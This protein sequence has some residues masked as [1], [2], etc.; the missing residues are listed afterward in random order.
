MR[1]DRPFIQLP[2]RIDPAQL[3]V[4]VAALPASAWRPHPEGAP[5]NSAVPLV[6]HRGD[7][8]DERALPPM[9]A[10]PRLA[11]LP[12]VRA[13]MAALRAP[14]GRSRL[15]RVDSR[16]RLGTHVDT[17]R[18]WQEHLRVHI[19]VVTDP[20]VRFTCDGE[21]VHMAAGEVWVFDTWRE[22][23]V[24]NPAGHD[25]IHLV[26]DTVGSAELWRAIAVGSE[27]VEAADMSSR[28]SRSSADQLR[29]EVNSGSPLA[30]PW[31]QEVLGVRLL[32]DVLES[33]A[34]DADRQRTAVAIRGFLA[35]WRAEWFASD[36]SD[37]VS[38]R[39]LEIGQQL[40]ERLADANVV[41]A[42]GVTIGRAAEQLLL[43][44]TVDP[45][46]PAVDVT[47][48]ASPG[49][50]IERPIFIVSPPRSGSALL[51][52]ALSRASGLYT[53]G[54]ESHLVIESI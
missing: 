33:A 6:C 52:E 49:R 54:G 29:F 42:N 12:G 30:T 14:I 10:S 44:A 27:K 25:R 39:F 24:D 9:A 51:F 36:R 45:Q 1:L 46:R 21:D 17:N 50:R 19:P 48:R 2:I 8:D 47:P 7:P 16:G 11:E 35:D 31:Q 37:R 53:I 4:E 32:G 41:L 3:V 43:A 13:A 28:P 5:G 18:Y 34:P 38:A 40:R 23:G 22:H 26:I 15:M 20:S